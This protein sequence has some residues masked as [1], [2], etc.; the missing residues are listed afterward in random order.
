MFTY[1]RCVR[2]LV[3]A[4]RNHAS[5]VMA[6]R[7]TMFL[8]NSMACMFDSSQKVVCGRMGASEVSARACLRANVRVQTVLERIRIK[9]LA[10]QCDEVME[11]SWSF[12]WNITGAC[13]RACACTMLSRC[14][15]D[16]GQL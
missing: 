7:V 4:L 8:M 10:D 2:L 5:D 12:I 13:V 1:E 9:H 11:V 3:A 6:Q 15:R 16:D 14:R